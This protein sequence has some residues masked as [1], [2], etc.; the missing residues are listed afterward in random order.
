MMHCNFGEGVSKL[1]KLAY[2]FGRE[3]GREE[4]A[5]G[6]GSDEGGRDHKKEYSVYAQ[7][8]NNVDNFG[9]SL[10]RGWKKRPKIAVGEGITYFEMNTIN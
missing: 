6:R 4:G 1:K 2:S 7:P 10:I 8:L 5:R 9:R 3:R